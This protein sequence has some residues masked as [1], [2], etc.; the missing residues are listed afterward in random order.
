MNSYIVPQEAHIN[1]E[2]YEPLRYQVKKDA[3]GDW[4]FEKI[5]DW[6]LTHGML[7]HIMSTYPWYII[8]IVILILI[9]FFAFQFPESTFG[10]VIRLLFEWVYGFFEDIIGIDRPYRMKQFVVSLFFIILVSNLFGVINDVV[11][12]FAPQYLR[13][14]TAPT[15]EFETNIALALIWILVTLY[16]QALSLGWGIK[17]SLKLIHEFIPI[18]GKWLIQWWVFAKIG[19]IIISMF[20]GLLDIVGTFAKI[21]SLSIR[22]LGNMS[23]G[24]ILLNVM[25]IGIGGATVALIGYNA[26]IGIPIVVYMQSL[27]SSIIQAFV[28]S[29]LVGIWLSMAYW[30]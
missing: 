28:F 22:L 24:S 9:R 15:G 6:T 3:M 21:I 8:Q 29:L 13:F 12:F 10:Q 19:D 17:W 20:I 26:P 2:S 7:I 16:T 14:V 30:D 25:F 5:T 11:R 23:S 18:T 4:R 27:L 1:P